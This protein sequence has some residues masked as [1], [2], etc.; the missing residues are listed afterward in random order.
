[1]VKHS[2]SALILKRFPSQKYSVIFNPHTGSFARLEDAGSQEPFWAEHGPELLDIAITNWCDHDCFFCYRKSDTSGKHMALSDYQSIL[3]QAREMHVFQVAL[4]GG[5]PNQHPEFTEFLRTTRVDFGIVPNYTTNGRGLSRE[6]LNATSDYCGAVAVSAYP[7]FFET[8][9]AIQSLTDMGITTNVHF[10]LSSKN[11]GT[12]IKWLKKPPAFLSRAHA[13][14]FLNYKPVGRFAD[15]RLLANQSSRLQEF[16]RL[17]TQGRHPWRI[18]F[19]TC[20][21]T[22]LAR[23]GDVHG[24]SVEGC[25]AGRFSM[26]VSEDLRAYP[27]SFMV[28]AGYEGVELSG[29]SLRDVW[30][31]HR[32]FNTIR[33]QHASGGCADCST[34]SHCLSGCPIFPQMNLCSSNCVEQSVDSSCCSH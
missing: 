19:D 28:E 25:D 5:N 2:S 22:G 20:T 4:G 16:F 1:M 24:F 6:V 30:Q 12:A 3:A 34:P 21:I 31:N 15:N 13:I 8:E 26:F 27:C 10:I 7:P 9:A 17:A 29:T 11:I 23:M 32:D 18:G 14:V 33:S